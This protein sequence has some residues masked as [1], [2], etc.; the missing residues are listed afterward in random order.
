[1]CPPPCETVVRP[2]YPMMTITYSIMMMMMMM[3]SCLVDPVGAE[4]AIS[5]IR[6]CSTLQHSG[7][8][9]VLPAEALVIE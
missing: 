8:G 2:S 6:A 5:P 3:M 9:Y 4:V 7:H 1:M